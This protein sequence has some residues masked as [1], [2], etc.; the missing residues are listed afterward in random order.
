MSMR[1]E[2]TKEGREKKRER[3][4]TNKENLSA[5]GKGYIVRKYTL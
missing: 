2:E 5:E 4:A 3:D 1:I